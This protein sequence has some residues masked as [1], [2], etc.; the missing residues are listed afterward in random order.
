MR[1]S[2]AG[3]RSWNSRERQARA[4]EA[5]LRRDFD[6]RVVVAMRYWHPFTAEAI[7]ELEAFAPEEIV[8]LPL[9]PQ[10]S[11]DHHGKQ[12]ERMETAIPAER[13]ESAG[14]RG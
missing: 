1:K 9:Y 10:Y 12:L 13:L 2:G 4:L 8:L 11:R 14:A 6:A 3:R 7:A 5:E